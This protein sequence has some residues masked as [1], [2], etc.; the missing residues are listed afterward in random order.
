MVCVVVAGGCSSSNDTVRDA[1]DARVDLSDLDDPFVFGQGAATPEAAA[2][3]IAPFVRDEQGRALILRGVNVESSSK[4]RA[5]NYL[6][7]SGLESQN[8]LAQWGWNSVRFLVTW[9]AIEPTEGTYDEAYLDEVELWLDYY[10][11]HQIHVTLD[12]HQDLYAEA[13]GGDGAPDWAVFTDGLE[14]AGIPEGQPWYLAATDPATQAAY[15]NFWD[16]ARG[17]AE[18]L[19]ASYMGALAH[20]AERFAN[21]PAVV[22]YDIMNEPVFANG[23]LNATLAIVGDAAAGTFRNDRLIDFFQR[24]IDA[25]RNVDDDNWIFVEPTSL[26]NAFPYATDIDPAGFVDP[27][28]GEKRLGYAPHLYETAVHDGNPY[29]PDSPYVKEWERLRVSEAEALG[30]PLWFGEWG[31]P[32]DVDRMDDYFD[33]ILSMADRARAGWSYWSWDPGGWSPVTTDLEVSANGRRLMR[34]Q[35]R[36]VAG[37]P[38]SFAWNGETQRFDMTW[39]DLDGVD[40]P[41]EVAIP[42]DLYGDGF[43]VVIDGSEIDEPRYDEGFSRLAIMAGSLD[44]DADEHTVCI[45]PTTAECG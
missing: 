24:A 8:L 25:I 7:A 19:Q 43:V 42:R 11:A 27:R 14:F 20:L 5:N 37:D 40:A 22:G 39:T 12:M 6:P 36:A 10:A 34:V 2:P 21:H 18:A 44:A 16:P 38:T 15:Q 23:D 28:Q 13:F 17:H 1:A 33:D 9:A 4:T 26:L 35:P 31:G 41:T 45:A 32:P 29:A 30:G 3:S